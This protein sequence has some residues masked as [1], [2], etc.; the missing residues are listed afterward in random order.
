MKRIIIVLVFSGFLINCSEDEYGPVSCSLPEGLD[1]FDEL[2]MTFDQEYAAFEILNQDWDEIRDIYRPQVTRASSS[3]VLFE[4]FKSMLFALEDAHADL[5]TNSSLGNIQYYY[6][7]ANAAPNNYIGWNDL[8]LNYL[9][10]T[11][12]VNS[13]LAYGSIKGTSIG[14]LRVETFSGKA[15][16]FNL[17]DRLLSEFENLEGIV[18]DIRNND[19]GEEVNG[20]EI[21]GRLTNTEVKY[22]YGRLKDGC[23]P[24]QLTDFIELRYPPVGAERFLGDVVLLTNKKTFSA[25]EDFTLMMTALPNVTHIGDNTWGGFATGPDRKTLSNG[26]TYRVSRAVSYN[27]DK[28]PFIGG[29]VPDEKIMISQDEEDNNIDRILE[30]AIEILH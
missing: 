22:R 6:E 20:Y 9:E 4:V 15:S 11:T 23:E 19:G 24:N 29:I 28:E 7:V 3:V 26:W 30:R 5:Q 13:K 1:M 8:K 16:D 17:V 12:E 27:L 18:V 21:A 25:G 10:N 2:W 14:Y